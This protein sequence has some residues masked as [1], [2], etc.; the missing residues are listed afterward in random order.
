M[1]HERDNGEKQKQVN[2][3]AGDMEHKKSTQPQ[4]HQQKRDYKKWSKSHFGLPE[5]VV[6]SIC[7]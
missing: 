7:L 2:Q 6:E 5:R 4:N 3:S 1:H